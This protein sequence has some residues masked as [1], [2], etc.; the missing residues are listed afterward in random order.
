MLQELTAAGGLLIVGIGL[1][2]LE[3]KRLR[4]AN[5]L[6]ALVVVVLL[7]MGRRALGW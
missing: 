5:L 6:P 2:L 7:T 1:L 4:V 3:I